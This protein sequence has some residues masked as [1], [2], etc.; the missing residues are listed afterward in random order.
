MLLVPPDGAVA[1]GDANWFMTAGRRSTMVMPPGASLS[2]ILC[3]R[4]SMMTERRSYAEQ[5]EEGG[6]GR[7]GGAAVDSEGTD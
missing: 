2:G 1:G 4:H 7:E 3:A 5:D 6:C